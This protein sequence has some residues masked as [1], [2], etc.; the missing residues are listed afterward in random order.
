MC[1]ASK[2]CSIPEVLRG[3]GVVASWKNA[4]KACMATT[5]LTICPS[6]P[7][8]LYHNCPCFLPRSQRCGQRLTRRGG[9]ARSQVPTAGPLSC[10]VEMGPG[11]LVDFPVQAITFRLAMVF[12]PQSLTFPARRPELKHTKIQ[13]PRGL[14]GGDCVCLRRL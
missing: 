6:G 7:R 5:S 1:W 13:S 14:P 8:N 3:K 2:Q 10:S 4:T 11:N 12:T 9:P